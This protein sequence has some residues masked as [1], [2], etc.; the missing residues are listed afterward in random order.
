[1]FFPKLRRQAKWVFLFLAVVFALGFVGFGVGA[2]GIGLG[3]VFQGSGRSGIPSISS[4]ENRIAEN[5]N[6]AQA[7][8]DL[9]TGHQ[10]AGNTDEAIEALEGFIR[11]RPRNLDGLREL[12][13]LYLAKTSEAQQ[14]ASVANLRA[15]YA[16]P[17]AYVDTIILGGTPLEPDVISAAVGERLS[18]AVNATLGEAQ[19]ASARAV[20]TYRRIAAAQPR[21]PNVQLELAQAAQNAGD[22]ATAI[23]AFERFLK[24][25]PDD[26]TVPDVKR[27]L[28]QLRA[29][30]AQSVAAPSS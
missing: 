15:S 6:D 11:I 26:P 25:A 28:A 4:A 17:G 29:S 10:A 30:Q 5:P 23:T 16:V 14:E 21:D 12:A 20:D 1:M 18:R 22:T 13:A 24:I 7:Y 8:R 27:I 9:A 3:N 19:A 2:G